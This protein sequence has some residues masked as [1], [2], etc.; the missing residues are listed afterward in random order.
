MFSDNVNLTPDKILHLQKDSN[1]NN[2]D[3][4]WLAKTKKS[5]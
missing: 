2:S 1:V 5:C 3:L 4:R